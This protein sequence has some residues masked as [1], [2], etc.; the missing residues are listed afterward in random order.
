MH[1]ASAATVADRAAAPPNADDL[2]ALEQAPLHSPPPPLWASSWTSRLRGSKEERDADK[3]AKTERVQGYSVAPADQANGPL[4]TP[5]AQADPDTWVSEDGKYSVGPG[6]VL[7][8]ELDG[9]QV[10]MKDQIQIY[11]ANHLMTHPLVSPALQPSLGGL[12]PLLITTG[13][14]ELLKDE[15]IYVAHKAANPLAYLP[16]P[17]NN[18]TAEQ[19]QAQAA[20]YK[21]TNV[22]LQ[23]WD[24]LCHVCPT[25]SFTRPAKHMYRSIAQFGAWALARA[26]DTSID[27]LDDDD[28]SIVS[29][30][31]ATSSDSNRIDPNSS[32][33]DAELHK[34]QQTPPEGVVGAEQNGEKEAVVGRAGDP[35]PPF[36]HYMIRQRIDR[37][38][39]IY[40]LAPK[41]ELVALNMPIADIGVPKSGPVNKYMKASQQWNERF[42]K[43]KVKIQKQR[44]KEMARGFEP[45]EGETPP[46]TAL[47]GRR[48]KGMKTE[49]A[50]K[51]SWGMAM[52]SLWGSKHD[53]ATV[54]T[55]IV[56]AEYANHCLDCARRKSG[57]SIRSGRHI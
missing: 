11:T 21:P 31:S 55:C 53:Q 42:S 46:P 29:T 48:A 5:D 16:P 20:K 9:V 4:K 18:Q 44:M 49:R 45:F 40:P 19:I 17:S 23:V 26:Q 33:N 47:A 38:G 3:D 6:G 22:Q 39:R 43:Q 52:W 8:L 54:R 57:P 35:L 30:D 15:Q 12:P 51:K 37:H 2:R 50:R 25:L 1:P 34:P 7:T 41:E 24:D 56:V 10:E 28:I 14:G 13:G 27:I 32:H 36:D